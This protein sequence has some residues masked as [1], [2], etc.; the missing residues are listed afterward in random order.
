L[1]KRWKL[2]QPN[3]AT[4]NHSTTFD[5]QE[6]LILVAAIVCPLVSFFYLHIIP[7]AF[8]SPQICQN[9]QLQDCQR[10]F[11]NGFIVSL[12]FQE[13]RPLNFVHFYVSIIVCSFCLDP[14]ETRPATLWSNG[15]R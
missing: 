1:L 7:S 4:S 15:L 2:G 8:C 3:I 11:N 12:V 6:G 5:E 13:F 10:P 14:Q 9:K